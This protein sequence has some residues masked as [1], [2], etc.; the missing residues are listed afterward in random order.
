MLEY[1]EVNLPMQPQVVEKHFLSGLSLSA[2]IV[3][4][5]ARPAHNHGYSSMW[6]LVMLEFITSAEQMFYN[7]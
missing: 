1:I 3:T 2:T 5:F 7:C 4:P 6:V